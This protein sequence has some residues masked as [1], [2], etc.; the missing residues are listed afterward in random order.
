MNTQMERP[1]AHQED[2]HHN[3]AL[4][5]GKLHDDNNEHHSD[6]QSVLKKRC[7][8]TG[9][10]GVA[11]HH[12]TTVKEDPVAA[13]SSGTRRT[14][15]DEVCNVP[16]SQPCSYQTFNPSLR[17]PNYAD[18]AATNRADFETARQHILGGMFEGKTV[19]EKDPHAPKKVGEAR[20]AENYQTKVTDPTGT[21][22]KEIAITPMLNQLDK[23]AMHEGLERIP[24][25]NP[26]AGAEYRKGKSY[27]EAVSSLTTNIAD[28]AAKAK[29]AV[30]SKLGN[31]MTHEEE[32]D[33]S[34]ESGPPRPAAGS[35][36]GKYAKK[37]ATKVQDT[38]AP[39]YEKLKPGNEEKTLSDVITDALPLHKGND[40][41]TSKGEGVKGRVTESE[42]VKKQ[43]GAFDEMKEEDGGG[44]GVGKDM[45]HWMKE[46]ATS[47]F[48][49]GGEVTQPSLQGSSDPSK[50]NI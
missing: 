13:H 48:G 11:G 15:I 24:E 6:K 26:H 25:Q 19:L 9:Q 37:V 40:Q 16:R 34:G 45:V 22:T 42:E 39:V 31:G 27:G 4:H 8:F 2:H 18:T 29:D 32:L 49:T 1:T 41:E 38:L 23:M 47:W 36:M 46:T 14:A 43:L 3:V 17:A 20:D 10:H 7:S 12:G 35:S 21:G 5:S 50:G 44:T 30:A 28:K 33:K